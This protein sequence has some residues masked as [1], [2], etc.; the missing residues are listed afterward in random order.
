MNYRGTIGFDPSPY[1]VWGFFGR[2]IMGSVGLGK[3]QKPL[4]PC[5]FAH[6]GMISHHNQS[7]IKLGQF[8][9]SGRKNMEK[10]FGQIFCGLR[11]MQTC[12]IWMYFAGNMMIS[13]AL[14]VIKKGYLA[15]T[16]NDI[17]DHPVSSPKF[18]IPPISWTMK[19]NRP[20]AKSCFFWQGIRYQA[21]W[22]NEFNC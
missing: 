10:C 8:G 7:D 2:N 16:R 1:D 17:W 13:P 21:E 6:A 14:M 15:L 12:G 20:R 11:K 19:M 5:C 4:R 9:H 18:G 22:I 3:K